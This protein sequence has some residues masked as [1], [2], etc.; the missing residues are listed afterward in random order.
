LR[1]YGEWNTGKAWDSSA[2]SLLREVTWH[3][4]LQQLVFSPLAEQASLR[5][6]IL[7]QLGRRSLP[8]GVPLYM[9]LPKQAGNQSELVVSFERPA[10]AVNLSVRVMVDDVTQGGG[11]DC[12]IRYRPNATKIAVGCDGVFDELRL[13]PSDERLEMRLFVDNVFTET[14][15]MGGRVVMTLPS[16]ACER[17]DMTVGTDTP[18][19]S[20]VEAIAYRVRS[21]WV[22]SEEVL[23][24]ARGDGGNS[25][26][27][28]ERLEAQQR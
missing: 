10:V 17:C 14:Y 28:V 18:G 13:S 8:A 3:P 9:G 25:T 19:V 21:I 26:L 20:L 27:M 5:D 2:H 24:T 22:S 16:K 4:E 1:Q 12:V 15:W 6:G 7:G 23:R 11:P